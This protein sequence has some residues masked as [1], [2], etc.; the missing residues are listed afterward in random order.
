[1]FAFFGCRTWLAAC[2][3]NV[4]TVFCLTCTKILSESYLQSAVMETKGA[5][6]PGDKEMGKGEEKVTPEPHEM[7]G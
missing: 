3:M 6:A 7:V 2:W 5:E 1:M 4:F